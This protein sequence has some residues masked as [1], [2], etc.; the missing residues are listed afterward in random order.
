MS[1]RKVIIILLVFLV[2]AAILAVLAVRFNWFSSGGVVISPGASGDYQDP[3]DGFVEDGAVSAED[4]TPALVGGSD[5]FDFWLDG[6]GSIDYATTDGKILR[7]QADGS[8]ERLSSFLLK[9]VV[10]FMPSERGDKVLIAARDDTQTTFKIFN[11]VARSWKALP[12]GTIAANWGPDDNTIV[13]A[14]KTPSDLLAINLLGL[15]TGISK[16]IITYNSSPDI[17]IYYADTGFIYIIDKPSSVAGSNLLRL[18]PQAGAL[19]IIKKNQLGLA[20]GP[21]AEKLVMLFSEMEGAVLWENDPDQLIR[22]GDAVV[23]P[24]K[25]AVDAGAI[26]CAVFADQSRGG[27]IDKYLTRQLFSDDY[28]LIAPL[29]DPGLTTLSSLSLSGAGID[30]WHP[31]VRENTLYFLNRKDGLIYSMPLPVQ[32]QP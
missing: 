32:D 7:I 4:L 3:G 10:S 21:I 31:K 16:Q 25:C 5:V 6:S 20:F 13:Y 27:I 9:D 22:W 1:K 15:D 17:D 29:K 30:I 28:L 24:Q 14:K 26:Y 12:E 2:L 19:R 11:T 8:E 18:D 23:F